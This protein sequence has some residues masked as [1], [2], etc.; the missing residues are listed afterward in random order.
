GIGEQ[1]IAAQDLKDAHADAIPQPFSPFNWMVMVEQPRSYQLT[2][3]S[4]SRDEAPVPPP[5]DAHWLTRVRLSYRPVKDAQWQTVP[6][7]GEATDAALAESAWNTDTLARYRQFA[8]F[9][10]VYRIDRGERTCVWFS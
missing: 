5:A 8:L 6:R 1:Y 4:L 2:Y 10:A 3:I 9:P 7:F